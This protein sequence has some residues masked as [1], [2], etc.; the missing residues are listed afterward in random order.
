[1]SMFAAPFRRS[2]HQLAAAAARASAPPSA[3][4]AASAPGVYRGFSAAFS[5]LGAREGIAMPSFAASG[6][7]AANTASAAAQRAP[8]ASAFGGGAQ[9]GIF[10][11]TQSTPNPASLMFMPGKPVFEARTTTCPLSACGRRH[12][13]FALP[14]R[15][16]ERR[17]RVYMEVPGFRPA[18]RTYAAAQPT[19]SQP[20]QL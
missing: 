16:T 10:I 3:A 9:R 20:W 5:S 11:Q 19:L 4:S 8:A 17:F 6:G 15:E 1:M 7:L 2:L 13:A 14:P 18:P 12:Q